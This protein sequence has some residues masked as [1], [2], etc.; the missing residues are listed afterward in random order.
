MIALDIDTEALTGGTHVAYVIAE[1]ATYV[2]KSPAP[3]HEGHS[4]RV[5]G[6]VMDL[7]S[8][9]EKV[10]AEYLTGASR[11][12]RFVMGR[13]TFATRYERVRDSEDGQE[14]TGGEV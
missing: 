3:G 7:P 8:L 4:C 12:H 10:L 9:Q 14:G 13:M 6:F 11:G 5:L 2:L 1:G